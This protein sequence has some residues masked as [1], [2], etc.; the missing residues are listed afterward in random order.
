MSNVLNQVV[1]H[2][3]NPPIIG[4]LSLKSLL[5]ITV[6]IGGSE[7]RT[8]L[9]KWLPV[10]LVALAD[11]QDSVRRNRPVAYGCDVRTLRNDIMRSLVRAGL[12]RG[13]VDVEDYLIECDRD[14]AAAVLES[15]ITA[16]FRGD[17]K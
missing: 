4:G 5:T 17:A 6:Q 10:Y 11:E 3:T 16:V 1:E 13:R 12:V 7:S 14:Q 15:I 2:S 8:T 9:G